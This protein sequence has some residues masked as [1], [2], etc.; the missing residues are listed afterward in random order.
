MCQNDTT[1][2]NCKYFYKT[3]ITEYVFKDTSDYSTEAHN[4][5]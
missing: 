2:N 4:I 1:A 5:T 3:V